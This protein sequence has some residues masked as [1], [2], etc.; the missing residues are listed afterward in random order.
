[1]VYLRT[2]RWMLCG[3][4]LGA[5][6]CSDSSRTADPVPDVGTPPGSAQDLESDAA[7]HD[8][9]HD[10]H[11]HE[12]DH[13]A[14]RR[15]VGA[16]LHGGAELAVAL[17]GS[18]LFFELDTPMFNLTGF[19]RSPQTPQERAELAR[20]K[21]ALSDPGNLFAMNTEAGCTAN[22]SVAGLAALDVEAAGHD[23]HD[24]HDAHDE[25]GDDHDAE[26]HDDHDAESHRDIVLEFSFDCASPQALT[27]I[28]VRLFDQ[29]SRI[30]ELETVYLD[31]TTQLSNRL[32]QGNPQ[33]NL[34]R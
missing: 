16:H 18:T 3:L 4:V 33:L 1:M 19:E 5:V 7:D 8:D 32:S 15:D 13:D 9:D 23:E 24:E 22:P 10:D 20:S 11:G 31:Q 29:F 30:E 17:D 34:T 27:G 25:H 6:A 21:A 26:H 2:W 12:D 28:T 14:P